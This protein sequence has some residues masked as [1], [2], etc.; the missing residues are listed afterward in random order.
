MVLSWP[1]RPGR[2]VHVAQGAEM[3][4]PSRIEAGLLLVNGEVEDLSVR[5]RVVRVL[6]GRLLA[7][8]LRA[9]E[10]M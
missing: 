4:R 2:F 5:G 8:S 10:T 7:P 6:E 1:N 3:G 9:K